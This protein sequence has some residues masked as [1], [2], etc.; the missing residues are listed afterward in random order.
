MKVR[1]PRKR[2]TVVVATA[3]ALALGGGVAYAYFT[4]IGEG[5]GQ[6][7]VGT[8]GTWDVVQTGPA[9]GAMTPGG[10]TSV[11]TFTITNTG[12]GNQVYTTLTPT[13]V[14]DVPGVDGVVEENG[15]PV[16]GCLASWFTVE[17][18]ES[19]PAAGTSIAGGASATDDVTV[20][21]SNPDVNQ[22]ACIDATPDI[23]LAVA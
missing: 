18:A 21:M 13:V 23:N 16:A 22:D 2:V 12:T 20:T 7:T 4:A 11:V 3:M 17:A 6:A 9:V 5:T 1:M 14:A 10:D 15:T 8:S 19:A